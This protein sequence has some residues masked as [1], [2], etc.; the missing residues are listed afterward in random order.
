MLATIHGERTLTELDVARL[1][2]L[3]GSQLPPV[4]AD[5]L[6]LAEV[7]P[8]REVPADIVT[9]YSQIEIEDPATHQTQKITLCY[10]ADA[11]PASGFISVL[12]P[13][14]IGLL[15]VKAG[16]LARWQM[17]NGAQGAARVVA[18]LFQ[19]EASGDYTT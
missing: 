9:M 3:N 13:V 11:E 8:S 10:P 1:N 2:K 18:I 7:L 12:S 16:T 15:G 19:P 17:P 5:L 4:L 6:D 14:G